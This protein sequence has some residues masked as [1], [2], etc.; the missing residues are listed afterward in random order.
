MKIS[1]DNSMFTMNGSFWS[2]TYPLDDL[3]KWLAFYRKQRADFPKARTVYDACVDALE[4]L[5]L[6]LADQ[7]NRAAATRTQSS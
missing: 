7:S 1:H 6:A 3:P 4:A 2:G 5:T